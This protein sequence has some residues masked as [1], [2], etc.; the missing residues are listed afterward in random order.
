MAGWRRRAVPAVAVAAVVLLCAVAC[1]PIGDRPGAVAPTPTPERSAWNHVLDGI[2][3]DGEITEDVALAAFSLV[4]GPVPGAVTPSD[5]PVPAPRSGTAALRWVRGSWHALDDDQRA[6]VLSVA[7]LEPTGTTAA[8]TAAPAMRPTGSCRNDPA[9]RD[10]LSMWFARLAEKVGVDV[11]VTI[12]ACTSPSTPKNAKSKTAADMTVWPHGGKQTCHARFF[13]PYT[14]A[15]HDEQD[16]VLAHEAFHCLQGA[17]VGDDARNAAVPPWVA[18]GLA[19]W[20]AGAITGHFTATRWWN[21]YLGS[22]ERSLLKRTYD[23]LGFWWELDYLGVDVWAR[24]V[25]VLRAAADTRGTAADRTRA[26]FAVVNVPGLLDAWP[27]SFLRDGSRDRVW[28]TAGAG[29]PPVSGGIPTGPAVT[30][31][32]TTPPI[33]AEPFASPLV[34]VDVDAEVITLQGSGPVRGRFGPGSR[35]KLD[36]PLSVA[37]GQPFCTLGSGRCRCPD[38]SPKAGTVFQVIEP[39]GLEVALV[40]ITGGAA[41]ASVT[42]TGARLADF[43]GRAAAPAPRPAPGRVPQVCPPAGVIERAVAGTSSGP[44]EPQFRPGRWEFEGEALP[45]RYGV[46]CGYHR[47]SSTSFPT[48]G[49]GTAPVTLGQVTLFLNDTAF[50]QEPDARPAQ[51]AGADVAWFWGGF[52]YAVAGGRTL[53]V[54]TVVTGDPEEAAVAIAAAVL[55]SG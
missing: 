20:A 33:S 42:L 50:P 28:D 53:G 1:T 41:K 51:V 9:N 46:T 35:P 16:E 34:V 30:N 27:A 17:I 36:F 19:D 8:P 31:G 23:A 25:P 24:V 38:D 15:S 2:G 44:V 49:G 3:P 6:A 48:P 32:A 5:P 55:A 45:A 18:E 54:E 14:A 39:G 21:E 13:T 11:A 52:L 37:I 10:R 12:T 4:Y 7:E 22:S 29:L 43:C 47:Y 40:A 26:A